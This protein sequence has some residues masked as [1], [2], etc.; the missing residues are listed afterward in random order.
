[1]IQ[2]LSNCAVMNVHVIRQKTDGV[3]VYGSRFRNIGE[4]GNQNDFVGMR[5]LLECRLEVITDII[6]KINTH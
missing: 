5:L 3:F 6:G 2:N 1:M 4:R